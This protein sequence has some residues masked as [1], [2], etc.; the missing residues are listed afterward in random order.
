[1]DHTVEITDKD[2]SSWQHY[3]NLAP[4]PSQ[5]N[6]VACQHGAHIYFY[7]VRPIEPNTELLFDFSQE[8]LERVKLP[9]KGDD[10]SKLHQHLLLL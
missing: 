4:M 7:T 3:M 5:Q 1:L 9:V 8:Y 10:K 2:S 6:V